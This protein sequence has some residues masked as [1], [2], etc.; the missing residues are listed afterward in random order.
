[1][2]ALSD[3]LPEVLSEIYEVPDSVAL[4][5]IRNAVIEFCRFSTYVREDVS[6]FPLPGTATYTLGVAQPTNNTLI[7][8]YDGRLEVDE[9]LVDRK[10]PGQLRDI[11]YQWRNKTGPRSYYYTRED[12][13]TVLISPYPPAAT[14]GVDITSIA[15]T[16][17]IELT[18]VAHGLESGG[19]VSV[20]GTSIAEIDDLGFRITKI[21]DDTFSLDGTTAD[22]TSSAGYFIVQREIIVPV[23][24]Q[25]TPA[26]IVIDDTVYNNYHET[27]AYG[28]LARL[29][30][31]PRKDW[32]DINM[33]AAYS[34]S[35]AAGID[36]AKRRVEDNHMNVTRVMSYGGI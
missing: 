21:D 29:Y 7:E 14:S 26:S 18:L 22:G 31:M 4:N 34:Q 12:T 9:S 28:A 36:D 10:T 3:F 30:A 33:A 15:A 13:T 17:P 19:A 1:M 5:A 20:H 23:A 6:V 24:V 35:F 32:S 27:I 2:A 8:T 16:T 25:P 11:D